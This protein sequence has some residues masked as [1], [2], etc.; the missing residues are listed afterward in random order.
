MAA[1][2]QQVPSDNSST[3]KVSQTEDEKINTKDTI[4]P[5]VAD[6]EGEGYEVEKQKLAEKAEAK[7][8]I[9]NEAFTWNVDGDQS[10][11]PEVAACVPNTDDPSIPCN[12]FRAWFLLTIFV[13]IFAG[14]NQFFGLR[15]PSLTIGYVVAQLLVFPIGRAWEKLPRWRLPLGPLSFDFNPG[16]FT[17]KEHALIV[18][19]S[20]SQDFGRET[21]PSRC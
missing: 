21:S 8:L 17:M 6:L 9:P 14:A 1:E 18:I 13:I 19:V 15:Y 4:E 7:E 12:T 3:E 20:C 5:Y 16:P 2:I 10:P 11:F